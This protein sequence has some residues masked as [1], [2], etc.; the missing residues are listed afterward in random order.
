MPRCENC[1]QETQIPYFCSGVHFCN[2]GDPCGKPASIKMDYELDDETW[3]F[4][5]CAECYDEWYND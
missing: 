1:E 3:I 5:V 4:W 2:E